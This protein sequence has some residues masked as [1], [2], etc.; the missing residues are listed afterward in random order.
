MIVLSLFLNIFKSFHFYVKLF[1]RSVFALQDEMMF[2]QKISTVFSR[3][4][5]IE[6]FKSKFPFEYLCI[7]NERL[8]RYFD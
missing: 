5:Q 7:R 1:F 2:V 4:M 8:K 3:R 6:E